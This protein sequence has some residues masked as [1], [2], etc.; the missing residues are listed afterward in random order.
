M[1]AGG[2]ALAPH[3]QRS[4][5]ADAEDPLHRGRRHADHA[6]LPGCDGAAA[7]F[8]LALQRAAAGLARRATPG[9]A[10]GGAHGIGAAA[11]ARLAQA[12]APV[13]ARP[14]TAARRS[15]RARRAAMSVTAG[16]RARGADPAW[17]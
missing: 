13:R 8:L 16:L 17:R 7:R 1:G 4:A 5:R 6:R 3:D 12:G 15:V 10:R 2:R 9:L 14:R 11:L